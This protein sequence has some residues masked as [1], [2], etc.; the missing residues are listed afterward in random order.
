[1]QGA[2]NYAQAQADLIKK[3]QQYLLDEAKKSEENRLKALESSN[4]Q[5]INQLNQ[6]KVTVNE[7][8]DS[9][10][11]QEYLYKMLNQEALNQNLSRYRIGTSGA[12][13][14]SLNDLY[15]QYG[16]NV[17]KINTDRNQG[18]RDIDNQISDTNLAYETNKNTA[19]SEEALKRLQLQQSIDAQ[20][21]DRYNNAYNWFVQEEARKQALKEYEA[22]Q[23]QIEREYQ[24]QKEQLAFQ[25]EY[26]QQ[27]LAYEKLKWQQEYELSKKQAESYSYDLI[28]SIQNN[29]QKT[30]NTSNFSNASA[31]QSKLSKS[32][33]TQYG[34][35][36]SAYTMKYNAWKENA[37]L[38]LQDA[39]KSGQITESDVKTI[40]K[41]LGL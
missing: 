21:L 39:L 1:M 37:K 22:A 2:S 27:Q 33:P 38:S 30:Q 29:Q 7:N 8:A 10:N 12:R 13:E 26:Q 25:R 16:E 34:S 3:Q 15:A 23:A 6:N 28:D 17:N 9:L 20:A 4:Q 32:K 31:L 11:R 14:T 5:A 40:Y 41:N 36:N 19:L 24:L 18:L 35:T